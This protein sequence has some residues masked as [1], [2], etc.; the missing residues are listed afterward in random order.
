[1]YKRLKTSFLQTTI[2][3]T[4]ISLTLA[5]LMVSNQPVRILMFWR[6]LGIGLCCGLVFGVLYPY[7]WREVTWPAPVIIVLATLINVVTGYV[8]LTLFSVTM[9][10]WLIPF[11]W[12]VTLL[13]LIGH[14]GIFYFYQRYQNQK[15]ARNLNTLSK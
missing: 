10:T 1:M 5:T 8:M 6:L 4:L 13:T 9:V 14:I 2:L 11:W 15:M 7:L 12:A 3:T